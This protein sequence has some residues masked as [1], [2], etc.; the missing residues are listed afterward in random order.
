MNLN[1]FAGEFVSI[2]LVTGKLWEIFY[3]WAERISA[4][5]LITGRGH[6]PIHTMEHLLRVRTG[7]VRRKETRRETLSHERR[8]P[9]GGSKE[10]A[11]I[12]CDGPPPQHHHKDCRGQIL[13]LNLFSMID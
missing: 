4:A 6:L 8:L 5:F 2:A 1:T 11:L 10:A 9:V 3:L 13:S 7:T 12:S